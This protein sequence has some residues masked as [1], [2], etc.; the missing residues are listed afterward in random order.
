MLTHYFA[1]P[2][3]TLRLLHWQVYTAGL[4][5]AQQYTTYL[6]IKAEAEAFCCL[7]PATFSEENVADD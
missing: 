7:L 3:S 6:T 5:Q 2:T 1:D 4:L